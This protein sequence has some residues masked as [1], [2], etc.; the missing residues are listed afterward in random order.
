MAQRKCSL[1]LRLSELVSLRLCIAVPLLACVM[2]SS[3]SAAL[4]VGM[5]CRQQRPPLGLTDH[6]NE[7]PGLAVGMARVGFPLTSRLKRMD[8]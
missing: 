7:P 1:P 6:S 4:V 3:F 8:L 2:T 5:V